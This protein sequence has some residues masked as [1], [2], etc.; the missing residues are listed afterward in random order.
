MLQ[1]T[2]LITP[3]ADPVQLRLFPPWP[4]VYSRRLIFQVVNVYVNNSLYM[5]EL[6]V[7]A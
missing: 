6:I 5:Y 3:L 7:H 1:Y 2:I 4:L